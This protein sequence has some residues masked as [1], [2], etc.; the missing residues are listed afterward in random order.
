[1]IK[2]K[3]YNNG[4]SILGHSKQHICSEVSIAMFNLYSDIHF[5][6]YPKYNYYTSDVHAPE[7]QQKTEGITYIKF[8]IINTKVS[9]L[10]DNYIRNLHDWH[11]YNTSIE[12]VEIIN[13]IGDIAIPQLYL[14]REESYHLNERNK[15]MEEQNYEY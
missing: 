14:D 1:M 10:Y 6:N 8:D 9:Y 12:E 11:S 7:E 5:L 15:N 3:L 13:T 2:I 4:V